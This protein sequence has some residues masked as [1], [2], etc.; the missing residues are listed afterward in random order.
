MILMKEQVDNEYQ[1]DTK[2]AHYCE[3]SIRPIDLIGKDSISRVS[4]KKK[5]CLIDSGFKC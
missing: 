3:F 2:L 5:Y 4:G 1:V